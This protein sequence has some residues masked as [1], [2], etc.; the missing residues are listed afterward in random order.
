MGMYALNLFI[1]LFADYTTM[2][3][4][5][6]DPETFNKLKRQCEPLFTWCRFNQIFIN[7]EKPHLMFINIELKL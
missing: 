1:E 6:Y 5:D 3:L 7:Y 4:S 2:F